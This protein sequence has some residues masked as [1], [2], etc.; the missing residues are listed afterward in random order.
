M[1]TIAG[2][3]SVPDR[4][5]FSWPPP[6]IIGFNGTS[7]ALQANQ[8]LLVHIFLMHQGHHLDAKFLKMKG[9]DNLLLGLHLYVYTEIRL[10]DA[11][12][13]RYSATTSRNITNRLN[14]A[15]F[16]VGIHDRDENGCWFQSA[17]QSFADRQ[18][19]THHFY[20]THLAAFLF[21]IFACFKNSWMFDNWL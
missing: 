18:Y 12:I 3:F 6:K 20:I 10:T 21:Y 8:F 7:F 1:P 2:T 19:Q 16:I 14:R 15:D 13:S 9:R 4:K 17:W 5:P 11:F